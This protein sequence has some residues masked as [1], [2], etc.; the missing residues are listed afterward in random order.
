MAG[1]VEALRRILA[2]EMSARLMSA[3][4]YGA[5]VGVAITVIVSAADRLLDTFARSHIHQTVISGTV[6]QGTVT[7]APAF[8]ATAS[9]V[10]RIASMIPTSDDWADKLRDPAFWSKLKAG[11][12]AQSTSSRSS[13]GGPQTLRQRDSHSSTSTNTSSS[14]H[15]DGTET[16]RTVCV[17]LCDGAFFP[18]SFSTEREHFDAD[19]ARCESTC[20]GAR[21]YVH[22]NPGSELNDL[23]DIHGV[24]YK[25]LSTAFLF[26]TTYDASCKCRPHPWEDIARTQHRVYALQDAKAKG[27][28]IAAVELQTITT[29]LRQAEVAVA[30]EKKR[31]EVERAATGKRIAEE[32]KRLAA[33]K[34]AEKKRDADA[35]KSAKLADAKAANDARVAKA[36]DIKVA[37]QAAKQTGKATIKGNNTAGKGS[38]LAE[39]KGTPQPLPQIAPGPALA[40]PAGLMSNGHY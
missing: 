8:R 39:A 25:K 19:A 11:K 13:L 33:E 27:D 21:L 29:K 15:D 22:R 36:A 9:D 7:Q 35:K 32:Q 4:R 12:S 10:K 18:V 1:Y 30:V 3:V 14:N 23:E 31:I 5:V 37:R 40:P 16:F 6:I 38:G 20:P 26:R 24:A 34:T 2:S 17:R 28:R